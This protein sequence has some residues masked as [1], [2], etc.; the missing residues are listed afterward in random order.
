MYRF[1]VTSLILKYVSL[2][3]EVLTVV[4]MK[5]PVFRFIHLFRPLVASLAADMVQ[6]PRR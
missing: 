1:D 6:H 5:S 4:L 2:G 3:Y